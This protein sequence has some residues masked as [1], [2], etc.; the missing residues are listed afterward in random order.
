MT[1]T[2]FKKRETQDQ[3]YWYVNDLVKAA[4]KYGYGIPGGHGYSGPATYEAVQDDPRFTL[5]QW[6]D[7]VDRY[8]NRRQLEQDWREYYQSSDPVKTLEKVSDPQH[9]YDDLL[10]DNTGIA[11]NKTVKS[12]H[13]LSDALKEVLPKQRPKPRDIS[14]FPKLIDSDEVIQLIEILGGKSYKKDTI[15]KLAS[16]EKFEKHPDIRDRYFR[17]S[18]IEFVNKTNKEAK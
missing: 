10:R 18:V 16:R 11:T 9:C 2:S 8:L 17:D 5:K 7:Y 3:F 12:A 1:E 6:V 14:S 4:Y 15:R 13:H